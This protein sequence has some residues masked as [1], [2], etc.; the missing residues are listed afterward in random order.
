M[1]GAGS[2]C[3]TGVIND[4]NAEAPPGN[5]IGSVRRENMFGLTPSYF[6][7]VNNHEQT[8]LKIVRSFGN[9]F[10]PKVDFKVN[11]PVMVIFVTVVVSCHQLCVGVCV[12]M[13]VTGRDLTR[14]KWVSSSES[15]QLP[16]VSHRVHQCK[17]PT[18]PVIAL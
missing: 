4:M 9:F 8:V 15:Q 13:E 1:Q 10:S 14:P 12:L 6:S 3:F 18:Q 5:I 17:V 16:T 2:S 11:Y 7:I